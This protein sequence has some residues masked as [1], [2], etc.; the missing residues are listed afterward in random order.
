MMNKYRNYFFVFLRVLSFSCLLA[1]YNLILLKLNYD[2]I[3]DFRIRYTFKLGIFLFITLLLTSLFYISKAFLISE[4]KI[5]L[6]AFFYFTLIIII[7]GFPF[8]LGLYIN[9]AEDNIPLHLLVLLILSQLILLP[10]K[11]SAKSRYLNKHRKESKN[12]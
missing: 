10:I 2:G 5:L 7:V 1:I 8:S 9:D 12:E 6:L 3:N 4:M 11:N